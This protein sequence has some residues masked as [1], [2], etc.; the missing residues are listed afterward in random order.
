MAAVDSARRL[1]D[2]APPAVHGLGGQTRGKGAAPTTVSDRSELP[3]G[4][5]L[6]QPLLRQLAAVR[7]G[8]IRVDPVVLLLEFSSILYLSGAFSLS[9][10]IGILALFAPSGLGVREGILAIFL[11]QVMPT[12]VALVVSVASRLWIT[13]AELVAAG[14]VYVFVRPGR[15]HG[16]PASGVDKTP[17]S[18]LASKTT[19]RS[20]ASARS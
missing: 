18:T 1:P 19:N 2:R 20:A 9:S 8:S 3:P 12:S 15:A 17:L 6:R 4:A 11:N 14:I 7:R 5:W 13:I 10:V 16:E